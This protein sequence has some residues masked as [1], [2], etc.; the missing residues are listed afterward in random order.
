MKVYGPA[1]EALVIIAYAPKTPLDIRTDVNS[2]TRGLKL[3]NDFIYVLTLCMRAAK[4]LASLRIYA[5]SP[6]PACST[7]Q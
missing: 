7:N 3:I 5:D 6:A 2:G 1:R 4:A